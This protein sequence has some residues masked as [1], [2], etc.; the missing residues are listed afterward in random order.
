MGA[1][2]TS[3]VRC[4]ALEAMRSHARAEQPDECCGI[5]LGDGGTILKARPVSNVHPTPRT[6][7]TIDP[8]ALIDA[9]RAARE[10]DLQVLG[11]Y[12]SHP[13]GDPTPSVRDRQGASGDGSVWA[14]VA[15][16][17]VGWWR[18]TPGGFVALSLASISV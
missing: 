12:H 3:S 4:S 14:I 5:L 2:E 13:N 8:Q 1:T 15:G 6:R 10:G 11:Y 7:F 17:T 18:D 9:H 16:D